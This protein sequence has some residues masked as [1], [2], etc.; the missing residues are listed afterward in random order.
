MGAV[1]QSDVQKEAFV[2][3]IL[4]MSDH[5]QADIMNVIERVMSK[6]SSPATI[7]PSSDTVSGENQEDLSTV[8]TNQCSPTSDEYETMDVAHEQNGEPRSPLHLARNAELER[9]KRENEIL[10]EERVRSL[11]L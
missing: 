1:V 3:D 6:T 8:P 11:V 2:R 9:L 10:K 7:S 5:V 4:T